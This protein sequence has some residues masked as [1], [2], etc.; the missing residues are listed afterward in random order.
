MALPIPVGDLVRRVR[1]KDAMTRYGSK[2]DA[3]DS[4]EHRSI[5]E[6]VCACV[7]S[8]LAECSYAYYFNRVIWDFSGGTLTLRG[9]VATFHL[10]QM[11]QVIL[12]DIPNVREIVNSV[13]VVNATGLSTESGVR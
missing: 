8:R 6:E 1:F 11:L 4:N 7:A 9:Q 12:R 3:A 10:K 2:S 5:A 13:D